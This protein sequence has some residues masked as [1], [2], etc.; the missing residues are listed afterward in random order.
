MTDATPQPAS[1]EAT[2]YLHVMDVGGSHANAALVAIKGQHATIL[3]REDNPL[4]SSGNTEQI[5]QAITAPALAL[6]SDVAASE[7][8]WAIALP[9]PFD[10]E[11]GTGT[12]EGV[13][14]FGSIAGVDLRGAIAERLSVE[15]Q[16]V[17]FLNDADAYGIGEWAFGGT[18]RVS[19]LLCV[20]LGTGVGSAFLDDGRAVSSGPLVPLDGEAHFLTYAGLPIERT[21]SS[22]AITLAYFE[23]TGLRADVRE[24]CQRAREGDPVARQILNERLSAL[25]ETLAPWVASFGVETLVVGGSISQSWDVLEA[26]LRA[27]IARFDAAT[28]DAVILRRSTLLDAAPLLGA[29]EWANRR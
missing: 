21:M 9:A 5:L 6:Q 2:K 26:P 27:G 18:A 15:P 4:D 25:G 11:R 16:D 3:R 20:T 14:K 22:S 12:F 10:Y 29:A 23:Q 7:A 13:G 28:A 8:T 19:R 17:L 1:A 24:V